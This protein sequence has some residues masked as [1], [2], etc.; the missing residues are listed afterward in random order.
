MILMIL[1]IE[2][3]ITLFGVSHYLIWLF[4][5]WFIFNLLQYL[6]H[7]LSE[8]CTDDLSIGKPRLICIISFRPV[9]IVLVRLEIPPFLR[10]NLSFPFSLLLVV[11]DP[12]VLINLVHQLA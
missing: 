1:A 5:E 2:V 11:F 8:H 12:L 6:M 7:W 3:M 9:I 10:D 4:K